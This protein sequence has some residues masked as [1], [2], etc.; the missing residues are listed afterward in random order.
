M[1]GYKEYES[2]ALIEKKI[3]SNFANKLWIIVELTNI[4]RRFKR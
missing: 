2:R 4:R 1:G 3:M